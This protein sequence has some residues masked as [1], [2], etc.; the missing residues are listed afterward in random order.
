V[1]EIDLLGADDA[2]LAKIS[3]SRQLSLSLEEM[4]R[5]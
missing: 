5:V 1:Y 3:E 2:D 4:K